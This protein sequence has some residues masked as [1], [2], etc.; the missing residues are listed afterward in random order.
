MRQLFKDIHRVEYLLILF[1]VAIYST[2]CGNALRSKSCRIGSQSDIHS[3]QFCTSFNLMINSVLSI[4]SSRYQDMVFTLDLLPSF[5][6][7]VRNE[8]P[9]LKIQ[10]S[11]TLI[12]LQRV[13]HLYLL[14]VGQ[15]EGSLLPAELDYRQSLVLLIEKTLVTYLY[16]ALFVD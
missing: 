6:S 11:E 16:L 15:Q 9:H 8:Y 5:M 4:F 14:Q 12:G 2:D 7:Q 1:P 10:V 3:N 13:P